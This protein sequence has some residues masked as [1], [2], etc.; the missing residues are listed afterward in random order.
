MSRDK[1]Q[2]SLMGKAALNSNSRSPAGN[3]LES[4]PKIQLTEITVVFNPI[5]FLLQIVLAR[6]VFTEPVI[7]PFAAVARTFPL[8]LR[9][10]R[11]PGEDLFREGAESRS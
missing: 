1:I 10:C 9:C 4:L 11:H 7:F 2:E 6:S 5:S 3:F 8:G